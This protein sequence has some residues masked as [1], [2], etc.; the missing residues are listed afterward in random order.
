V[1]QRRRPAPARPLGRPGVRLRSGLVVL[2]AIVFVLGGRLVQ[3][4]GLQPAALADRAGVQRV[5]EVV[6]PATRGEVLDRNGNVL[7][8]SVLAK[9]VY[10][11]PRL[12]AKA[13]CQ[14]GAATPCDARGVA[15]RVAPLLGL[16]TAK[17]EEQLSSDRWFVYLKRG[18]DLTLAKKVLELDLPG[19]GAETTM[20][21]RHPSHDL[22][23]GVLGFTDREG[24]G[25]AGIELAF[26][27][28]LAG[29]D[30]STIAQFDAFGR[31]IPS[32][33]DRHREPVAGKD[34]VLTID[35]D[36][37]WYAQSLLASQVRS[38]RAKSGAAIVMD[39]RTGELLAFATAPTFDPDAR[40]E[41]SLLGNPALSDVFEPGSVNKVITAAAALQSG[42]VTPATEVVV[43]PTMKIGKHTLH[44]AEKHGTEHLTFAGV[45]AKSSNIGTVK[46][47]QQVGPERLYEMMRAFGFGEKS[48]LG[49][50]GESR[51]IVP[52]P[53]DWSRT[54][55]GT[56]PIGQGV[57]VN[58]LQMASVYATI[59]NGGVRV[60]PTVV[61]GVRDSA[62]HL[63]PA[64]APTR[65][66]VITPVVAAQI[67]SM[68]ESV[69]TE[70]GTAPKA[71]I[72]GYRVA[73]KTGTAQRVATS[74][75][76]AGH[77]DGTYTSSF[78]GIAPADAPRF[79]TAVILQGTR[80][81]GHFG[82][83]VAAPVF[84][85][86]TGFAL[87]AF[88]VAPTGTRPPVLRLTV[89]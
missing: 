49:L 15:A 85:K 20:L 53:E 8:E 35:R 11:E 27:K 83:L 69:V 66:T 14:Q 31:V 19:I 43:P 79:V 75:P 6:I 34:V 84:S 18:V 56:I 2:L 45:L 80:G 55:I 42:V 40:R 63:T 78:I 68:L 73:G 82:G 77:Y 28:A 72:P 21:R 58:A 23:A 47:A 26:D 24:D 89:K 25:A 54:S 30:G 4:Q 48:G 51:G 88:E 22:A 29:L 76:R 13:K 52:R 12:L 86:V 46:V 87:R 5:R 7:A 70:E 67:R 61:K 38:T 32:G 57:S 62:G 33:D 65:R 37:Q 3:L 50:P 9:N 59:A 60:S 41:G 39:V 81:Y 1:G 17:V 71:A 10:A 64:A 36:L 16:D 74:G 44:D